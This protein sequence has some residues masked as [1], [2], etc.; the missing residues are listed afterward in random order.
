MS[1]RAKRNRRWLRSLWREGDWKSFRE[2]S[3]SWRDGVTEI[4][5]IKLYGERVLE[6]APRSPS[7][8]FVRGD[9]GTRISYVPAT[10]VNWPSIP[11]Q[12]FIAYPYEAPKLTRRGLDPRLL[13]AI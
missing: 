12:T 7:F 4:A 9:E 5:A 10:H 1:L 8:I 11:Q 13:G 6:L 2:S 3:K